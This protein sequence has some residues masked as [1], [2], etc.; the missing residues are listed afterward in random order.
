MA[1]VKND[2]FLNLVGKGDIFIKVAILQYDVPTSN[3]SR[4]PAL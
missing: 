3:D 2:I 4:Q 1:A